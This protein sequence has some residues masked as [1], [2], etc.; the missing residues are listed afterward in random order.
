MLVAK[1]SSEFFRWNS[2][3]TNFNKGP[4]NVYGNTGQVIFFS[5]TKSCHGP[6]R[7]HLE[8]T[9]WPRIRGKLNNLW[10]RTLV[11]Q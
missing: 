1:V 9:A 8:I 3:L 2:M 11:P 6:V 10:P 7:F 5:G 4:C